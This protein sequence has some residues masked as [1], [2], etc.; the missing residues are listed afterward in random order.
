MIICPPSRVIGTDKNKPTATIDFGRPEY[1]DNSQLFANTQVKLK[2][3]PEDIQ[4]PYKFPLGIT[5]ISYTVEDQEGNINRCS[6][7][8]EV[9]GEL[10][11]LS[12]GQR[13][14]RL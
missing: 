9:E 6:F 5:T 11:S 2:Q 12:R 10:R 3:S 7:T 13:E 1:G 4:T 8:I 14:K